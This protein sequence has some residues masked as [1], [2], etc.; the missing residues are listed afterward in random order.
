MVGDPSKKG[1]GLRLPDLADEASGHPGRQNLDSIG[2][3]PAVGKLLEPQTIALVKG[4]V[5]NFRNLIHPGREIRTKDRCGPG[6][7]HIAYGVIDQ[8]VNEVEANLR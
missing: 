2:K 7:A 3:L 1:G 5:A 4:P 6:P 8:V